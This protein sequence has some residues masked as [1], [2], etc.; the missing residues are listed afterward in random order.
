MIGRVSYIK[1]IDMGRFS[2]NRRSEIAVVV[3][4]VTHD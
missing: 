4:V 2:V 3:I 1:S